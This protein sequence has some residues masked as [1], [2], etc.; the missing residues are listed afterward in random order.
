MKQG[1]TQAI[2]LSSTLET[3]R[4][5]DT[6]RSFWSNVSFFGS[7][8]EEFAAKYW[9]A[10][11]IAFCVFLG[12]V[13][14]LVSQDD[15]LRT[16][17]AATDLLLNP[18]VFSLIVA[19]LLSQIAFGLWRSTMKRTFSSVVESGM[20]SNAPDSIEGFLAVSSVFVKEMRSPFRFI[21]I[22]SMIGFALIANRFEIVDAFTVSG[23]DRVWPLTMVVFF[24]IFAYGIGA[25]AWCLIG[26]A[27]WVSRLS[28][29]HILR[30]QPGHSDGCCG[31]KD[32]GDCCLQSVVP[33]LIGMALCAFWSNGLR[34]IYGF[35]GY[36]QFI[37]P[38]C[39]ALILALFVIACALVFLPVMGLHKRLEAHKRFQ[40]QQFTAE[41]EKEIGNIRDALLSGDSTLVKSS[42]D[43]LKL[44]QTLD[45]VVLKLAT[46]PFDRNSLIKYG[47]TPI[48][49]LAA[50][51]GKEAIKHLA[52]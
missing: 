25:V 11:L 8:L 49:S 32:V 15:S 46:W 50:S 18:F 35:S 52:N 20:I 40:D 37:A 10:F 19:L 14:L 39:Y 48:A 23:F 51:F 41:L 16:F 34:H 36:Q 5:S 17:R 6:I 33:L 2:D 42:T 38:F 12:F 45:P 26:A 30:I 47:L 3:R 28:G 9:Y 43:R 31:L 44:I 4:S 21:P 27:R 29:N 22:L 7:P 13:G 24:V 1:E